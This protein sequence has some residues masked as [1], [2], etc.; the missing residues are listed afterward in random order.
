MEDMKIYL[1]GTELKEISA[2]NMHNILGNGGDGR[3]HGIILMN[4]EKQGYLRKLY[5]I[6]SKRTKINHGRPI[7]LYEVIHER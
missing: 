4:L 1:S 2:D 3:I 7:M 6:K 5:Y